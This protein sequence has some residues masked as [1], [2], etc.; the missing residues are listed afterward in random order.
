M[1]ERLV[2][3]SAGE[4]ITMDDLPNELRPATELLPNVAADKVGV[5]PRNWRS[6]QAPEPSKTGEQLMIE[7]AL[8]RYAGDKAKAAR[9]IGWTS[10]EAEK[11]SLG[12]HIEPVA[13]TNDRWR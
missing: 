10:A 12:L 11:I 13:Y 5:H 3:L 7:D 4:I 6:A 8:R 1:L 2:L 9:F